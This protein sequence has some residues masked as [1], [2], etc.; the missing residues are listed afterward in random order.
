[1][2]RVYSEISLF[3]TALKSSNYYR[4]HPHLGGRER[5]LVEDY[6]FVH[7]SFYVAIETDHSDLIKGDIPI[8]GVSLQQRCTTVQPT[9]LAVVCVCVCGVG[10]H[11]QWM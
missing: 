5:S 1:M 9:I 10:G 4:R 3:W 2:V 6:E 11:I 7:I 8:S